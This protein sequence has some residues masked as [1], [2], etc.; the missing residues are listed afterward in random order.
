VAVD[1]VLRKLAAILAADVAGYSRLVREDEEG[2]LAAVKVDFAEAFDPNIA[3]HGGRTFK[4]MGDG[5]LAEFS[6]VV[7]AVRCAVEIQRTMANRNAIRPED[8]RIEFRIGIN[9][10]DVVAQGDDLHGDGVNVSARLEGIADPGGICISG[11]AFD[12][13]QKNVDVG[14]EFLGEREV[15][16]I[17][18]PVRVYRVLT[19]P[20]DAGKLIGVARGTPGTRKWLAIAVSMVLLAAVAGSVAWLRPWG[21]Y[22]EPVATGRTGI[23]SSARPSIAVLPFANMSDEKEQEYFSDGMTED[24][25]TDLSRISALTVIARSS[26]SAYKGK[27]P[28]FRNIAKDLGVTHVI[29]GSVRKAGG[30]VRITAQLIDATT[31]AHLWANRYDREMKDIFALQDEVRS[32]IVSALAIKLTPKEE[33]LLARP[34]TGSP[35]AYELY[36]KGLA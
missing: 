26:T 17:A 25:I 19:N 14:Y 12:H 16:N 32:R 3:A 15:K 11:T 9:L 33:K 4:T 34:Q 21:K 30:R 1:R 8:R 28:D 23:L 5:L 31:G 35:E 10:G 7:D 22:D 24:L 27:S 6:S 2:T 13:I 20:D 36:L 18:Q 29:E